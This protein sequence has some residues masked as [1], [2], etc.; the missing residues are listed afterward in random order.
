MRLSRTQINKL[1][2]RLRDS[3]E[4]SE[5]DLTLLEDV[6]FGY[7]DALDDVRVRLLALGFEPTTRLKTTGTIVDKLRRERGP[8]YSLK[9]SNIQDLAGARVV[10]AGRL[11][12]QDN[13]V[14]RV[15]ADFESSREPRITDRRSAPSAGYRAVHVIVYV[16]DLPVEIQVRT[17]LQNAWAQLFE[18]IADSYGRDI[19]Y[20]GEPEEVTDSMP[21]A[22]LRRLVVTNM[23]NLSR[24]IAEL[25]HDQATFGVWPPVP[26]EILDEDALPVR[27]LKLAVHNQIKALRGLE[28]AIQNLL[29]IIEQVMDGEK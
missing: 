3:A 20:G 12:D 25:E 13:A 21:A 23:A 26:P 22:D 10:V 27:N 19:R 18:R 11:A 16:H 24:R 14:S 6:L 4:P 17:E 15:A 2:I 28:G 9:L 8:N 7:S 5:E 29:R 1:G